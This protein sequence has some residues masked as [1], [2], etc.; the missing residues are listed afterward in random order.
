MKLSLGFS[1]C[2]NDTFIFDAMVHGKID[3]EG[4]AFEPVL[5]DVEALNQMAFRAELDIT[6]L[7]YHAL[8]HLL[9]T[10][11]LLD[12]GSALGRNCG[13]LLIGKKKWSEDAVNQARI[14]IPGRYTTANFLLGLAYPNATHKV[15]MVFSDIEAAVLSGAVDLGLIIH[16][17]RFTYQDKGLVKISDLG[18]YWESTTGHPIPLG[19]IVVNRKLPQALQE[20]I[21]RVMARSVA[22]A[23][24]NPQGTRTYVGEHAQEM[25]EEVMYAHIGL[26]VNDFTLHLGEE[27]RRAVTHLFEQAQE[28]ALIPIFDGNIFVASIV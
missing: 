5:A 13:P 25:Q 12:A 1:P 21:N 3:T 26:Y 7:S 2:P 24:A 10:Y 17:N 6:K 28:K 23:Q 4:L 27:G 8:G 19:G 11:A 18:E 16:E 20:K 14:A 22:W 15:E 9:P